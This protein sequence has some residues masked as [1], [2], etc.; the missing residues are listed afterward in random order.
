MYDFITTII[1]I[2]ISD[3]KLC[4]ILKVSEILI[5]ILKRLTMES[6]NHIQAKTIDFKFI[7]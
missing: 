7:T 2:N 1:Q 6:N 4:Q 3:D 5:F